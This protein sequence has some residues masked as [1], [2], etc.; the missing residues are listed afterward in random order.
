MG[1]PIGP[2]KVILRVTIRR[3]RCK[4]CGGYAQEPISFCPKPY[5]RYTKAL[6]RYA[7]GLRKEMSI[8][9]VA[10][11]TG[12]HWETVKEIEK[13]YLKKKYNRISLKKVRLMGID[14]VYLGRKCGYITVVRDLKRG[15]VLY[16]GK[17][18][19]GKALEGFER[20]LKQH[21]GRIEAVCIDMSNAY[22]AWVGEI[23]PEAEIVYDHFHIIKLMNERLD[24]LRR[25][26]MNELESEEKKTL[27]GKR[28]T[29]LRNEDELEEEAYKE[30]EELRETYSDLGTASALKESLRWIYKLA[31]S[32]RLA[33]MAFE[34]WCRKAE[35]SG[36]TCLEK[37]SETIKR[38]R[39][40]IL[41]Y[42]KHG[43]TNGS[44]EGFNN[45]IGWLTRQ[46]YGYDDEEYLHLKIYDLPQTLTR[47]YL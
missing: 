26:T 13:E 23:V 47:K 44:Q 39:S 9:A 28:Y 33:E 21:A 25:E 34:R 43:I 46:A 16:I 31:N 22:G 17:G 11:F 41:A 30:L 3:V 37:M 12:L 2:K 32:Y 7:I 42:W 1:L 4:S 20:R 8:T 14:E 45:K 15:D 40:G 36:V 6:A 5:V 29:L 27:K 38:H 24:G 35:A 18:K 10:H 19:G